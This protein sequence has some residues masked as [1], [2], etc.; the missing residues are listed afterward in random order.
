[1]VPQFTPSPSTQTQPKIP[2]T[3][4]QLRK[5]SLSMISR[6]SRK[7]NFRGNL[8]VLLEKGGNYRKAIV[9]FSAERN[10]GR[11]GKATVFL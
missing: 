3:E 11:G 8:W 1:M 4:T 5:H 7:K 10:M 2:T 6:F 9:G